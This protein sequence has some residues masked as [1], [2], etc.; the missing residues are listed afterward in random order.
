MKNCI[1]STLAG[2]VVLYFGG[3][4]LYGLLLMDVLGTDF[5]KDPPVMW[6]IPLAQLFGGAVIATVLGWRGAADF[7]DG[8]KGAALVGLLISLCYGLMMYASLNVGT[9]MSQIA[10]DA[11]ATIV[12]WGLAGGVVGVVRGRMA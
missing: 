2:A 3:F 7:A 5:M 11:A 12:L 8:A 6:A 9:T 1:A 10:I 4:L